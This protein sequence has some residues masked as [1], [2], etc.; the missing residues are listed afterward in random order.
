MTVFECVLL[1]GLIIA[2]IASVIQKNVFY[3]VLIYTG[4]GLI[5]SVLWICLSA[6][7]LAITEAAVGTG[8]TGILFILTLKKI[9]GLKGSDKNGRKKE[10]QTE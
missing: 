4:F 1:A 7:D 10:E 3:T 6:P 5:M 8:V 9:R 2:G